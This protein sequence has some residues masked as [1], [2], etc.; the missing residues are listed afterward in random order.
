[1]RMSPPFCIRRFR[2]DD[3]LAVER[4]VL[5][6]QRDEFGLALS[7]DNQPDLRDIAAFFSHPNSAFWVAEARQTPSII[8]CIGLEALP[9]NLA[10][11]RKFMVHLDWRGKA[12]GV[13]ASLNATFEASAQNNSIT[14]IVLSTVDVTKAAQ[15]FYQNIGYSGVQISE[16]PEAFVPGVIDTLFYVKTV[17][18]KV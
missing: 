13:A 1:M 18:N 6:I 4:L 8:G 17:A 3:Q 16:L 15:R 7:A 14:K 9:G 12:T 2:R 10:A 11:M 5:T